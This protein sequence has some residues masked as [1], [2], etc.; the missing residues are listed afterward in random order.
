MK[1]I[2]EQNVDAAIKQYHDLKTAQPTTYDFGESAL[3]GLGERLGEMKKSKE[4]LRIFELNAKANPSSYTYDSWGEACI[5][6]GDKELRH[7][8][9]QEV[10]GTQ[11]RRYE[12]DR[13]AKEIKASVGV[14]TSLVWRILTFR[15][16]ALTEEKHVV[17]G[18]SLSLA[19]FEV[20]T[21]LRF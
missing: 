10:V 21:P 5:E 1:T 12:C 2:Q 6:A 15:K 9:L 18:D 14:I 8:E 16:A 19:G 13:E 3:D 4:A 7:Q 11:P 20:V 17:P